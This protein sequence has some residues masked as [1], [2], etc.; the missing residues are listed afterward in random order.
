MNYAIRNNT[1]TFQ[2]VGI[3]LGYSILQLLEYGVR[4]IISHMV[5]FQDFL[6]GRIANL[7]SDMQ[8]TSHE[9]DSSQVEEGNVRNNCQIIEIIQEPTGKNCNDCDG[10]IKALEEE[11]WGIKTKMEVSQK[12]EK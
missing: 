1:K 9:N 5:S 12:S 3:F 7:K 11:V 4:G 6:T 8:S 2:R 10:R